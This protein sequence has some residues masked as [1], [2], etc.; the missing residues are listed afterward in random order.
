MNASEALRAIR[1]NELSYIQQH[2]TVDFDSILQVP[3]CFRYG[4]EKHLVRETL[5]RFPMHR[6][7]FPGGFLVKTAKDEVFFL[8]LD[9]RRQGSKLSE[10]RW[11]LSFRIL[12]DRELMTLY[13][14]ERKMLLNMAVKRVVD[15]H[16]H[17]CPELVIGMKACEYAQEL[18]FPQDEPKGRISVVAEN[19]TSALDALQVLLGVTVGNQCLQILDIGK[20]NYTF[21]ARQRNKSLSLRLKLQHFDDEPEYSLLDEKTRCNRITLDEV[22]DFQRLLDGRVNKLLTTRPQDLFE[23]HEA[24]AVPQTLEYAPAYLPCSCC[25]EGVLLERVIRFQGK[26]YCLP[27]FHLLNGS[28]RD[29][30]LH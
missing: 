16:G 9:Q 15:F 3:L 29:Q 5:G 28:G 21:I 10:C 18:L 23:V 20:H 27:C 26:P 17:L 13:R 1:F 25:G 14:N 24:E 4:R 22:V 12:S 8:Y 6:D 19:S 30:G 7:T 11:V 2:V